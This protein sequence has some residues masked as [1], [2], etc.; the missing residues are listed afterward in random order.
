[1]MI[2][3]DKQHVV[4]YDTLIIYVH[5]AYY[6][7]GNLETRVATNDMVQPKYNTM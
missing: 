3:A 2:I 1:M 5:H 6:G 4:M 7:F